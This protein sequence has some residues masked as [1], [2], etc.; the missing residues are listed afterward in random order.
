V[1]YG[2][3]DASYQ[4]ERFQVEAKR[5]AIIEEYWNGLYPGTKVFNEKFSDVSNLAAPVHTEYDAVVKRLY[6]PE[7]SRVHLDAVV[8]KSNLLARYGK[9]ASRR[10]PLILRGNEK[11]FAELTYIIPDGYAVAALPLAKEFRSPFGILFIDVRN[12]GN[13][14]SIKQEFELYNQRIRPDDYA[15]FR[16]FCLNVDDWENEPVIIQ[17]VR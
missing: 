11:A 8:H 14:V 4:R 16:E 6:D 5:K 1:E 7:A 13:K 10:W 15:A 12:E 2:A 3:A 9:K 17:K